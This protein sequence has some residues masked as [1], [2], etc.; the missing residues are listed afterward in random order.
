MFEL[1][2]VFSESCG[3]QSLCSIHVIKS[4]HPNFEH[5][6][7]EPD[8]SNHARK[9]WGVK[10]QGDFRTPCSFTKHVTYHRS[11][12][13]MTHYVLFH[14]ISCLSQT[15]FPS[16]PTICGHCIRYRT[17]TAPCTN[18]SMLDEIRTG[19]RKSEETTVKS[20]RPSIAWSSNM[21]WGAAHWI[22]LSYA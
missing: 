5:T 3:H 7:Y 1:S 6:K 9:K 12:A 19:T 21:K 14:K 16:R 8:I 17:M 20:T 10:I 4:T 18:N 13:Q 15:K 2:Q 11:F 22:L